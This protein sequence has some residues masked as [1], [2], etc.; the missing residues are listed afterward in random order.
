M[1]SLLVSDFQRSVWSVP[2]ISVAVLA[3]AHMKIIILIQKGFQ[4]IVLQLCQTRQL[5]PRNHH[6]KAIGAPHESH[7]CFKSR[8]QTNPRLSRIH[9]TVPIES[10]FTITT[11]PSA[12]TVL[13]AI[14]L[15]LCLKR[16]PYMK[17]SLPINSALGVRYL[18]PER[19]FGRWVSFLGSGL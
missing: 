14:K 7:T 4:P 19:E 16:T 8:T 13:S 9:K 5:L 6:S 15:A 10:S 1:I 17:H 11:V 18:P 2:S 12:I 3:P